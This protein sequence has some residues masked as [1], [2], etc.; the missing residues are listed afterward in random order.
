MITFDLQCPPTHTH[1]TNTHT[2]TPSI[3]SLE[4]ENNSLEKLIDKVLLL[5]LPS[6][7]INLINTA[8]TGLISPAFRTRRQKSN[9]SVPQLCGVQCSGGKDLSQ[10]K[11]I[12]IRHT[13]PTRIIIL[14]AY[15]FPSWAPFWK[16]RL[17]HR[18]R[19]NTFKRIWRPVMEEK[20][21]PYCSGPLAL[22][23][24]YGGVSH[25]L[26]SPN[27]IKFVWRTDVYGWLR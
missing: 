25:R 12:C 18:R 13:A 15:H 4:W 24:A 26:V 11:C 10:V 9:P 16:Q 2:H 27:W 23:W 19:V 8:K 20:T 7:K 17:T 21:L 22:C 1:P 14:I 5:L 6:Y 3:Q